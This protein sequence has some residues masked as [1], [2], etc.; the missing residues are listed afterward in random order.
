MATLLQ[1]DIST[2]YYVENKLKA[3][4]LEYK[5]KVN[6]LIKNLFL[7]YTNDLYNDVTLFDIF[8]VKTGIKLELNF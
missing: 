6:A 5:L 1:I 7:N 8:N 2:I 3:M 4:H